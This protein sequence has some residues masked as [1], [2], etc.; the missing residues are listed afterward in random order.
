MPESRYRKSSLAV[1]SRKL[2]PKAVQDTGSAAEGSIRIRE[3]TL[4]PSELWS[5]AFRDFFT[6]LVANMAADTG[7]R[8]PA[9]TASKAQWDEFDEWIDTYYRERLARALERYPVEAQETR[10]AGVRAAIV[11]PKDGIRPQNAR[12]VLINLHGGGF[13]FNRGLTAG[14]LEAAPVS[15]IGGCKVITLDYRQAPLHEYPAATEDVQAVYEELLRD[16]APGAIGIFGCS[17]GGALA[18]QSVAWFDSKRLPCPGAIGLL[19]IAPPPPCVPSPWGRGWGDSSIWLNGLVPASELSEAARV[20]LAP[21]SWYMQGADRNDTCAYPGSSDAVLAKFPPT[22]LLSGTRDF[23][24]SSVVAAHAR[25]L[26][27][28]V[29][30]SLY[31]IEGAP[32]GAHILAVGTP[33]AHDAQSYVARWFSERLAQ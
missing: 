33:E 24:L 30:A 14:Q 8:V 28:N 27:L 6:A 17:A 19:S 10:I 15:A 29:D 12:R 18:A 4:P 5:G 21:T 32:H 7:L 31:V 16:Y 22:L 20:R 9:R 26:K 3:L 2:A 1:A 13:V 23:A 25:F 11:T